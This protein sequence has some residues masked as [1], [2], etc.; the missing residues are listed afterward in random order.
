MQYSWYNVPSK[1][2]INPLNLPPKEYS[3]APEKAF[4]VE[5]TGIPLTKMAIME[6]RNPYEDRVNVFTVCYPMHSLLGMDISG[7]T[8]TN[9]II[10]LEYIFIEACFARDSESDIVILTRIG[11]NELLVRKRKINPEKVRYITKRF[12]FESKEQG[13][14][15]ERR[16]LLLRSAL[17]GLLELSSVS[18]V[19]IGIHHVEFS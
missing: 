5:Q 7:M 13:P 11:F 8:L 3:V 9:L 10:D 17:S 2:F 16:E 14:G 4:L 6:S 19:S 15:A 12:V 1:R 18:N